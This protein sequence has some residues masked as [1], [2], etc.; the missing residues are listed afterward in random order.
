MK[1][2]K[3]ECRRSECPLNVMLETLGDA[4]SLLIVRDLMFMGRKTF[5]EFLNAEEKIATNILAN[6]LQ[7]LEVHGVIEK[8]RNPADARRYI[9][10]LTEKGM[11]L[12]PVLVE[13]IVW[14]ARHERTAAPAEAIKKMMEDREGFI[15]EVRERWRAEASG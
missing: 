7:R 2:K 4:W 15:A 8:R 12:A 14:A 1:A 11:D 9:Y 5:N 3:G 10:R 13:M 6:R